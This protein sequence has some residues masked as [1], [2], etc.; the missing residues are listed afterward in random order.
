MDKFLR[1]PEDM[2]GSRGNTNVPRPRSPLLSEAK[3]GK[4]SRFSGESEILILLLGNTGVGKSTFINAAAGY[5]VAQVTHGLTSCK[6]NVGTFTVRHPENPTL[7]VIFIEWP[8]FDQQFL[9][10]RE[11]LKRTIEWLKTSYHSDVPFGGIIFLHDISVTRA[12]P[13]LDSPI[14]VLERLT[15]PHPAGHVVMT[16]V[17]WEK[18]QDDGLVA[19]QKEQELQG[20][21]WK[22]IL[23]SGGEMRRFINTADSAWDIVDTLLGKNPLKLGTVREDLDRIHGIFSTQVVPETRT[24]KFRSFFRNLFKLKY[25]LV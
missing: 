24:F 19:Q 15:R 11:I 25:L 3:A 23:E 21:I 5:N 1:K 13:K 22:R 8:G 6:S 17:R 18:V 20:R 10:D 14:S 12:Q 2:K 7:S 16:T 4:P 9:T